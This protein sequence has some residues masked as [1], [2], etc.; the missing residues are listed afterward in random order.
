MKAGSRERKPV[1]RTLARVADCSL[2]R[3]RWPSLIS[4]RASGADLKR[5][6]R[7]QPALDGADRRRRVAVGIPAH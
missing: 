2:R 3:F 6:S 7:I 5:R 1:P 4:A